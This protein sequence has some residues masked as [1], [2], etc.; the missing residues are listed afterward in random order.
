MRPSR[1]VD[2]VTDRVSS[3]LEIGA[4]DNIGERVADRQP[5][6]GFEGEEKEHGRRRVAAA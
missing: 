5:P 3:G 2:H 4:L 1:A 6:V